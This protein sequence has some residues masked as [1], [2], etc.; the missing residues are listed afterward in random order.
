MPNLYDDSGQAAYEA[1]QNARNAAYR[2][3]QA[4]KA[5]EAQNRGYQDPT[6]ANVGPNGTNAVNY[7]A[8]NYARQRAGLTYGDS[9]G[10]LSGTELGEYNGGAN[11]ISNRLSGMGAGYQ[12][13][14]GAQ[15]VDP[16]DAQNRAAQAY[17]RQQSNQQLGMLADTAN[18]LH[19]SIAQNQMANGLNSSLA[20]QQAAA[21][22]TRGGAQNLAMAQR[23]A[24]TNGQQMQMQGGNQQNL[25]R[26][27]EMTQARG[28][29]SQAALAQRTQDLQLSGMDAA[30]AANQ[31][32][33]E[34]AQMAENDQMQSQYDTMGLNAQKAQLA[35][36]TSKYG[37]DLGIAIQSGA[38]NSANVAAGVGAAGAAVGTAAK[39]YGGLG[40]HA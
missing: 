23:Q 18:G 11:D 21:N 3:Q 17:S 8:G 20:A 1:E 5:R 30:Q 7:G 29:Y 32:T 15:I 36:N 25:L 9:Y 26:A 12:G 37:S 27:Q 14:Q 38:Q 19:P 4:K 33:I 13:R 39:I 34:Q 35:A 24:A 16:Y 22:G 10:V 2:D 6:N 40:E 31:A 28:A